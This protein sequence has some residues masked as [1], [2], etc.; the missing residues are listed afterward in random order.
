MKMCYNLS[1]RTEPHRHFT[2][3]DSFF[4]QVLST[5]IERGREILELELLLFPLVSSLHITSF[6]VSD[7]E[8]SVPSFSDL[9]LSKRIHILVKYVIIQPEERSPSDLL[10]W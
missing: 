3:E 4:T 8:A 7:R 2:L 1:I 5:S 6:S 10:Y 9:F